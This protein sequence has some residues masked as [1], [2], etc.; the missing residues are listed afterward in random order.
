[1]PGRHLPPDHSRGDERTL[2]GYA[3][4]HGRPPAF[5]AP[6]GVAYSVEIRVD[7]VEHTGARWSAYLLFVKWRRVGASGP[8]GHLETDYLATADTE[9]GARA[10]LGALSLDEVERH[11]HELVRAVGGGERAWWDVMRDEGD[12]A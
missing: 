8:E 10:V 1:M 11:L 2:G 7:P 12:D 5:D 6:D 3:A 4:V 9:S